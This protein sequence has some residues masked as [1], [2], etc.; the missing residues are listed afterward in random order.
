[1]EELAD[2]ITE[3]IGKIIKIPDGKGIRNKI[4]RLIDSGLDTAYRLGKK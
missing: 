4:F 2:R 3:Q 1:M